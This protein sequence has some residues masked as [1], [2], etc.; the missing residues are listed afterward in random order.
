MMARFSGLSKKAISDG[1]SGLY[2]LRV[3]LSG[4]SLIFRAE[5]ERLSVHSPVP[6]Y[7]RHSD[8]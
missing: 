1:S 4:F 2:K 3:H 6:L 8:T 5:L 7:D